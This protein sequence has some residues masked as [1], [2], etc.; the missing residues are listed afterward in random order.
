M[1][2]HCAGY[3]VKRSIVVS[4]SVE[5]RRRSKQNTTIDSQESHWAGY[6]KVWSRMDIAPVPIVEVNHAGV[7]VRTAL[8]HPLVSRS[9]SNSG[10]C[11]C[12]SVAPVACAQEML[13]SVLSSRLAHSFLHI[14]LT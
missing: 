6:G 7:K 3:R 12:H 8:R 10:I 1:I 13:R 2:L 4:V 11:P 5:N 14:A 9:V